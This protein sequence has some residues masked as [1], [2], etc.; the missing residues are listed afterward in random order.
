MK[1]S[2]QQKELL[3]IAFKKGLV[4]IANGHQIWKT[5][6]A[7]QNNFIQLVANNYLKMKDYG[8]YEWTGKEYDL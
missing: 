5:K 3:D 7:I 6:E 1:L 8:L 4:T 2:N